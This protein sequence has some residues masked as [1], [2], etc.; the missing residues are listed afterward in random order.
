MN[1]GGT[2]FRDT[3]TLK[4]EPEVVVDP[5]PRIIS[6]GYQDVDG[7]IYKAR[8]GFDRAASHDWFERMTFMFG[9]VPC[10]MTNPNCIQLVHADEN[11][12]DVTFGCGF[13]GSILRSNLGNSSFVTVHY[14]STLG[15]A[16]QVVN[17]VDGQIVSVT[18]LDREI[19]P[20]VVDQASVIPSVVI[21]IGAIVAGPNPVSRQ[22]GGVNLFWDGVEIKNGNLL[23]Y[24]ASG[25][26]I[27][28][29]KITDRR[30]GLRPSAIADI[31][32]RRWVGEWDLRDRKGRLVS[33]GSYLIRGTVVTR[34]GKREKVSLIL[35]VR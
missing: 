10:L 27:K 9:A 20:L 29:I 30:D 13:P 26:F 5:R 33:E 22:S 28:K 19:P 8:F 11:S 35:G 3:V 21:T 4:I 31:H 6:G 1:V 2:P 16:P 32:N 23:V 7:F 18:D 15:W 12:V 14:N 25:N 24:D 17:I 34:G